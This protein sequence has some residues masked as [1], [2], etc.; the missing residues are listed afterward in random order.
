MEHVKVLRGQARKVIRAGVMEH[1]FHQV[2]REHVLDM[3]GGVLIVMY[4]II[5]QPQSETSCP[6]T[7]H[8]VVVIEQIMSAIPHLQ[9]TRIAEVFRKSHFQNT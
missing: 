4:T 2:V 6:G 3:G 9:E 7:L 5:F 1:Q 8:I